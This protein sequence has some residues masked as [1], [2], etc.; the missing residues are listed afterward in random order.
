M[1]HFLIVSV[2]LCAM[3][4]NVSAQAKTRK[5]PNNINHPSI[6]VYAP[7]MSF[8]ANALVFLSDNSE[9]N[10]PTMVYS[11]K[12]NADWKD[13]VAAPKQV[14]TRLNFLRG[15]SLSADG[16]KLYFTSMKSPGVGGYDIL[17]SEYKGS[18]WSEPQNIGVPINSKANEACASFSTDGNTIYFM[19]CEKMT[20]D[21]AENCKIFVA[22][23]KSNGQWD[24][25][26]ELPAIINKGNSQT[27]RILADG[28]SLIFSSDKITPSK[29]GMDLYISKFQNGNWTNP[30][31]L[32]FVNTEKDDQYVTV[33][34]LGRYL[35]KD[36]PGTR[37]NELVEYLIP[38]E[39]RPR[40]MMKIDGK[41]SDPSGAPTP[42]YI[43]IVDLKSNK[44]IYNGRPTNTG[45]FL[46]Y[47]MEG[48]QYEVSIDPE[49]SNFTY[50]AKQF[51]LSTDKIPQ[52]E[53]INAVLKPVAAGDE[54]SLDAVKFLPGSSNID[55]ASLED[56]KRLARV[57]KANPT[58]KFEIQ[59]L[60]NGYVE[61]T[62]KSSP[63]LTEVLYDSLVTQ[64]DDID[65]LGQMYKR[66]TL[67]LMTTFHNDRTT[68]QGQAIISY[69]TS[70][71][72]D[73]NRLTLFRNA[74]EAIRP[75]D[76]RTMVK[77]FVR[78]K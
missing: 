43:S 44:R 78:A 27:P 59:V 26:A 57:I 46:V 48:S 72:V 41:V 32:D 38:N 22:K 49:Q 17:F 12:E 71:G 21:K 50:Y 9:D 29:G 73:T 53:K 47:L 1:K 76:K 74:I 40:G 11:M 2:C 52:S 3:N 65:S 68:K 25:P 23:K 63:D 30:V 67:E 13:P 7:Y 4:Y 69:L 39:I 75:E 35:L 37:K 70:Q 8:D 62:I 5:L 66:D 55:P 56:L 45:S 42:A 6:N 77:A 16:K 51:D 36:T 10:V 34:A 61:D 31:A 58:L 15:Y 24:E 60:L 54:L 28:E 18:T 64:V 20:Q 19:R 33:N 14:N